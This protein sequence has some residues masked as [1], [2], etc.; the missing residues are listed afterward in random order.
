MLPCGL[1]T[2]PVPSGIF[3][4]RSP[5]LLDSKVSPMLL[6]SLRNANLG[7]RPRPT[8]TPPLGTPPLGSPLLGS[9]LLGS[10][11]LGS[12]LLGSPLLGLLLLVLVLIAA[13]PLQHSVAQT[14]VESPPDPAADAAE[15]APLGAAHWIPEDASLFTSAHQLGTQWQAIVRSQAIQ[16]LLRT[17]LAQFASLQVNMHP[18]MQQFRLARRNPLIREAL[19]LAEDAFS[20]E[21]FLYVDH[22]GADCLQ[23]L[24]SFYGA[25]WMESMVQGVR[26]GIRQADDPLAPQ[27]ETLAPQF[28]IEQLLAR[29]DDLRMPGIVFGF[30]LRDP[31]RCAALLAN[32]ATQFPPDA[33]VAL[34]QLA[35]G[36]GQY[37]S[38][39]GSVAELLPPEAVADMNAELPPGDQPAPQQGPGPRALAEMS[40]ELLQKGIA[41]DQ[42]E[43][44]QTFLLSQTLAISVGLRKDYILVS[45]GRDNEHL[46]ALGSSANLAASARL[47]PLHKVLRPNLLGLSYVH[48]D[49]SS[50]AAIA[51]DAF[52]ETLNELWLE[53]GDRVPPDLPSRVRDDVQL[54]IEEINA[55]LPESL[56]TLSVSFW[57]EGIEGFVFRPV[58]PGSL[59]ASGPLAI[60]GHAGID[61]LFAFARRSP[62]SAP[63]YNQLVDWAQRL[64]GYFEDYAQ[65]EIPPEGREE[66]ERFQTVVL[67]T[68]AELHTTT[69]DLLL[70]SL[71]G[72]QTLWTGDTKGQLQAADP[73]G[74]NQP[75]EIRYPRL[76][77]VQQLHD[78]A[79]FLQ[80]CT[81]YLETIN[82]FLTRLAESDPLVESTSL[83]APQNRAVDGG[84]VYWYPIPPLEGLPV[85]APDFEP[86]A[87][88]T[89]NRLI[90]AFTPEQSQALATEEQPPQPPALDLRQ[91]AGK[92]AWFDFRQLCELLLDD[93]ETI[94]AAMIRSGE[95]P[96]QMEVPIAMHLQPLR[97]ALGALG[98]YSSRTY[99][100]DR[101]Q[102]THSHWSLQDPAP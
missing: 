44:L 34:E 21:V 65:P 12:P 30:R 11:L 13:P 53:L 14:T 24:S 5:L 32:L 64:Y 36:D 38:I 26:Q 19:A 28:V 47:A 18:A 84:T 25:I 43:A 70:P 46:A 61:P 57:N 8:L 7:L 86:H 23:A 48:E 45:L 93:A 35:I 77:M 17:P 68:L 78:S 41:P 101:R 42:I 2:S 81:A 75:L 98:N 73:S 56:P 91:P 6:E 9:P 27:A 97:Q 4:L 95:I 74:A 83:P 76:A 102:I 66:F 51:P 69:R 54:L 58:T 22:H 20:Q 55:G 39:A 37:W 89:A 49:L 92:V 10:P 96:G 90:L 87:L 80:A 60:L 100:E 99:L 59:D 72:S 29:Q 82:R 94:V 31:A 3:A 16:G 85:S 33:P 88:L 67:P 40:A 50:A 63:A 1:D 71:D 79:Q 15:T 62:P 52:D